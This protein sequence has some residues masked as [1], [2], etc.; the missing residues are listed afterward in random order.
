MVKKSE[1]ALL[2]HKRNSERE[3]LVGHLLIELAGQI[4]G[5]QAQ[6]K[7][8]LSERDHKHW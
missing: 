7:R 4:S 8:L 5:L 6:V 1:A 3:V 2:L